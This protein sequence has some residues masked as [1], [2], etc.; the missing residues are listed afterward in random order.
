MINSNDYGRVTGTPGREDRAAESIRAPASSAAVAPL[1]VGSC[2]IPPAPWYVELA[3]PIIHGDLIFCGVPWNPTI[4]S[5]LT[6]N[7]TPI[8]SGSNG[9]L[10]YDNAGLFGEAAHILTDGASTLTLGVSATPGAINLNGVAGASVALRPALSGNTAFIFPATNGAAGQVLSTDGAGNTSWIAGGG[11]SGTVTSVTLD[12]STT[13]LQVNGAA[14]PSTIT[15]SGTFLLSGVLATSN[16]GTGTSAASNTATG[17]AILGAGGSLEPVYGGTGTTTTFA[18][19]SVIF[20]DASG[21]YDED[22]ANL[23]WADGINQ[24]S[25]GTNIVVAGPPNIQL[26]VKKDAFIAGM[27]VGLGGGQDS[28]NTALG[29]GVLIANT[30]SDNTGVGSGALQIN[31]AGSNNTAVGSIALFT[32]AA[33]SFNTAVGALA[34][35]FLLGG[36][37]NTFIGA[38]SS[39]TTNTSVDRNTGVGS[40]SLENTDNNNNTAV[41]VESLQS[42]TANAGGNTA[43]GY[44]SLRNCQGPRNTSVGRLAMSF[45][46]VTGI[47]N[48]ALGISALGFLTSGSYNTA[49]GKSSG[50]DITTGSYNTIIGAYDGAAA[51]ISGTG[52]N[53]IVL[54]DGAGNIGAYWDGSTK[55]QF[56]NGPVIMKSYTVGTLPTPTIEG[57]RAYVTDALAPAFLTTVVGGGAVKCP[58]FYNGANWVAG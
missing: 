55:N 37:D 35:Q 28:T 14:A 8:Y 44:R 20:A 51:P 26:N 15:T 2:P 48:T 33:G 31:A 42:N 3:N 9:R 12:P 47:E 36:T 10:A 41:G 23:Y 25:I 56:C 16:G 4:G 53:Y 34:A 7:A 22:N 13:G 29:S 30:G 18:S 45:A 38:N 54:S 57:M 17:V 32:N 40:R 49:L 5:A 11:G 24:L 19:G 46:T 58:V 50:F 52:N 39:G 1:A 27:T 6:V 43:V 21:N